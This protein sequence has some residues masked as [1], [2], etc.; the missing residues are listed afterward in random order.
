MEN[1]APYSVEV[2]LRFIMMY[3]L[4]GLISTMSLVV[5]LSIYGIETYNFLYWASIGVF[6]FFVLSLYFGYKKQITITAVLAMISASAGI[7]SAI[8]LQFTEFM[9]LILVF[10]LSSIFI[11]YKNWQ[12]Y[13]L[14]IFI[15]IATVIKLML[16]AEIIE[17]NLIS[18]EPRESSIFVVTLFLFSIFS[19]AMVIGINVNKGLIDSDNLYKAT[20]NLKMAVA[21]KDR[22]F[23]IISHDLRGPINSMSSIL[24]SLSDNKYDPDPEVLK[25]LEDS[26]EQTNLL[27]NNLL[28]WSMIQNNTYNVQTSEFKVYDCIEETTELLSSTWSIK[29]LSIVNACNP[30]TIVKADKLMVC[31]VIRNLLTNAIKFSYENSQVKITDHV[32]ESYI[33]FNIKDTGTGLT[34]E[35]MNNLF[36]EEHTNQSTEGTSNEKGAGMGLILAKEFVT[37]D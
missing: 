15:V 31:T 6:P 27:L 13:F 18:I 35:R 36:S 11:A 19:Y 17:T 9:S 23:S 22:L 7:L 10:I 33:K 14:S 28:S 3:N 34:E 4:I 16:E 21:S 30:E 8:T 1:R 32:S 24:K 37:L 2:R 20:K 29:N 26:S 5:Y 25:V 12:V